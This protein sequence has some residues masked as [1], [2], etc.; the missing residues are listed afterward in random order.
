MAKMGRPETEINEQKLRALLRMK[1]SLDDTAAFFQCSTKTIE[2][3][4]KQNFD[5]TFVEFRDQNMVHT[6]LSLIRK[7]IQKAENGDNIMLIFC[8][9][10][11]C[12]WKDRHEPTTE[13][14]KA[15]KFAYEKVLQEQETQ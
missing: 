3:F 4:I 8:L 12:G 9:K 6:R 15:F 1:P 11:L 7:A 5:V 14:V 13:D 2:R 10:N